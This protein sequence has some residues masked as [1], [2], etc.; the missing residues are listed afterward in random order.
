MHITVT[1]EFASNQVVDKKKTSDN[2][3]IVT[4]TKLILEQTRVCM[5]HSPTVVCSLPN[6][7]LPYEGK[8]KKK[9]GSS[10]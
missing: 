2:K 1:S 5:C 7:Q 8:K 4:N 10:S 3:Y 9:L 6:Q